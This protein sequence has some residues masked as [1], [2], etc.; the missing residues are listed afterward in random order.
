MARHGGRA[1]ERAEDTGGV[2]APSAGRRTR[3]DGEVPPPPAQPRPAAPRRPSQ[4]LSLLACSARV[5]ALFGR[6]W[7]TASAAAA[8]AGCAERAAAA[9]LAPA[10]SSR[11]GA[12]SAR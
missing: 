2:H 3:R 11:P 1:N 8:A 7:V 4:H 6:R 12:P 5:T 9:A 10:A